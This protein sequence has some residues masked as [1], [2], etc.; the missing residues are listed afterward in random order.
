MSTKQWKKF[1]PTSLQVKELLEVVLY[2]GSKS[3]VVNFIENPTI[4]QRYNTALY[5]GDFIYKVKLPEDLLKGLYEEGGVGG[6][7]PSDFSLYERSIYKY[8]GIIDACYLEEFDPTTLYTNTFVLDWSTA[9]IYKDRIGNGYLEFNTPLEGETLRLSLW[10]GIHQNLKFGINNYIFDSIG[11]YIPERYRF[12]KY[13]V[14]FEEFTP[15]EFYELFKDDLKDLLHSRSLKMK[16]EGCMAE[17]SKGSHS[18]EF[19][20]DLPDELVLEMIEYYLDCIS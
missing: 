6:G 4:S 17:K 9:K 14:R 18:V 5:S 12:N 13:D 19:K 3:E 1:H 8:D 15:S 2:L 16:M 7:T 20:G 10:G 11:F